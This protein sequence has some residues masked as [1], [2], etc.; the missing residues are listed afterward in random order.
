MCS[1]SISRRESSGCR[2]IKL[3]REIGAAR[4]LSLLAFFLTDDIECSRGF[5]CSTDV[6]D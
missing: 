6:F 1:D 4:C 2:N 5:A 3:N